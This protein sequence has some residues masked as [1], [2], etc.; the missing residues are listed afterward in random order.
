MTV[1]CFGDERE[2]EMCDVFD[3]V[4]VAPYF[5]T[6]RKG[7]DGTVG[8]GDVQRE[9]LED[10]WMVAMVLCGKFVEAGGCVGG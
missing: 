2:R 7:L 9:R 1:E 8:G 10:G 5:R 4:S 3:F 6:G